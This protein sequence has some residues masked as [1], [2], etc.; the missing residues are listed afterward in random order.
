MHI[1]FLV[2]HFE[3]PFDSSD[4]FYISQKN[5]RYILSARSFK[6]KIITPN[7][8][9]WGNSYVCDIKQESQASPIKLRLTIPESLSTEDT[10]R[11]HECDL[12]WVRYPV[13]QAF[14][15]FNSFWTGIIP[16]KYEVDKF[17]IIS[18][19]SSAM[20]EIYSRKDGSR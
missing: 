6:I 19:R 7:D 9:P 12:V 14:S 20:R 4:A 10:G 13:G 15:V 18:A 5:S 8:V 3:A 17:W 1:Q 16:H 2:R 11:L